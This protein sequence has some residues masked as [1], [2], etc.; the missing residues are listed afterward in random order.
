LP[1]VAWRLALPV[2]LQISRI[3]WLVDFLATAWVI[4]EVAD[5]SV[6]AS[7]VALIVIA[8][9]AGARGVYVMTVEQPDRS[10]FSVHLSSSPWHDAM[11]WLRRQPPDVLVLA[12]PGHAWKY[13][14]SVR[15]SAERDVV[16]EEQKDSAIA[17]YSRAVAE[18]V[19]DR[20]AAV[21]DFSVLSVDRARDVS[22]RYGV[23]YLVTE[24]AL[25][26]PEA[27]RNGQFHIYAMSERA[28]PR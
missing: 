5:A 11:A 26:L 27:Y 9:V 20:V 22:M 21:G 8:L 16:I 1:L 25:P 14:T 6:H 19:V 17:M 24:R 10:L 13:G 7:R 28:L 23:D 12:D 4:G 18:R 2:Q 15:V 3:F